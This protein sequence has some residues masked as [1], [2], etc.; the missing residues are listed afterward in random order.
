MSCCRWRGSE[1]LRGTRPGWAYWGNQANDDYRPT[2]ETY[3]Y[4]STAGRV[5]AE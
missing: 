5:A 4:N 1:K 3:A 2:W